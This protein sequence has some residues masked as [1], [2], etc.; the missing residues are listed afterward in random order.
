MKIIEQM[1]EA[2]ANKQRSRCDIKVYPLNEIKN[3]D[4]IGYERVMD[5]AQAAFAVVQP[6]IKELVEALEL[7]D[8]T[9]RNMRPMLPDEHEYIS[10]DVLQP[11]EKALANLPEGIL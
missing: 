7:A 2:I 9:I 3:I 10:V 1:A 11:I 5:E 4:P 6:V 8:T